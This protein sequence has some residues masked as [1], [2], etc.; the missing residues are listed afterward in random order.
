[1]TR[2]SPQI[3]T[4]SLDGIQADT[5]ATGI[6]TNLPNDASFRDHADSWFPLL[7]DVEVDEVLSLLLF[8]VPVL[9]EEA[10][11][12]GS[13]IN[14]CAAVSGHSICDFSAHIQG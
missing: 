2:Q 6:Q 10:R 9:S 11:R 4:V 7:A 13:S 14:S 3:N 1:M 8:P 12:V 5:N